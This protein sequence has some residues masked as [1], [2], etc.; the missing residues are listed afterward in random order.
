MLNN[1]KKI[2]LAVKE[3]HL[4]TVVPVALTLIL[5]NVTYIKVPQE[6]HGIQMVVALLVV[7]WLLET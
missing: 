3:L 6:V 5:A 2:R 7:K 1:Y 4:S